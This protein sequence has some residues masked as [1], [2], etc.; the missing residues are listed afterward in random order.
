MR[1]RAVQWFGFIAA[2]HLSFSLI[3]PFYVLFLLPKVSSV[4]KARPRIVLH[5]TYL[6]CGLGVEGEGSGYV[7]GGSIPA[8]L[9]TDRS[10][11]TDTSTLD[12]LFR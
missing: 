7:I 9:F 12:R 10:S 4:Q 11:R 8:N 6:P 1:E 3:G 5:D 2:F